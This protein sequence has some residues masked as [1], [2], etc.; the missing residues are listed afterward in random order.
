VLDKPGD[1][2]LIWFKLGKAPRRSLATGGKG[3]Q[4][5]LRYVAFM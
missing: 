4:A 3:N 2:V 5:T 1:S